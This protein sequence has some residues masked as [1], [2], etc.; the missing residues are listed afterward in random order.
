MEQ[1][2]LKAQ[3][4]E[5]AQVLDSQHC[6]PAGLRGWCFDQH[7]LLLLVGQTVWVCEALVWWLV[8]GHTELTHKQDSQVKHQAA[9]HWSFFC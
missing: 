5:T 9:Q 6:E 2:A 4:G 3:T 7:D 8:M 1:A